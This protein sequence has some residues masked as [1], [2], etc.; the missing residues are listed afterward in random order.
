MR[1]ITTKL[2][3][4]AA[5]LL[6]LALCG[7]RSVPPGVSGQSSP[8]Q[9]AL[10]EWRALTSTSAPPPRVFVRGD[11]I[12]FYFQ[13]KGGV[14][15]FRAGWKRVR[16][17]TPD[18][19]V[20]SAVLSWNQRVTRAP[21]RITQ[22]RQARVISGP[23]WRR[24][25]TNLVAGLAPAKPGRAAYYQA[26]LADGLLYRDQTGA[27]HYAG[28]GDEPPGVQ[29]EARYSIEE[30]LLEL[31]RRMDEALARNH[32]GES[33]FLLMAPNASRVTHPLLLDREQGQCVWLTPAAVLD[34][35]DRSL[36][37]AATLQG[38]EALLLEGHGW[39]LLKNPVS[40]LARLGDLAVQT[41]VRFLHLRLPRL[42]G[43][44]P[45]L[46]LSPGM[47]LAEWE[48]WLD[49]YTG[50]RQQ[51][52]SMEL[53]I[54]GPEFY[55]RFRQ[56]LNE[57]TNRIDMLV[58]IF[59]RD[60]VA[61]DMADL[62][63]QRS[64]QVP[65]RIIFDRLGTIGGGM[66]PPATPLAEGF[67]APNSIYSY[68]ELDSRVQ[69]R[70]YLN[71]WF[72]SEHSK[73][74]LVDKSFAWLGGMNIGREY[75]YEWHDM[76]V[77]VHGP[78]VG[79]LEEEF[80]REWAH[81]GPLGDAAYLGTFLSQRE[82]PDLL[83]GTNHWGQVRLLPTRTLWKPF[84]NAVQAALRKAK[85]YIWVENPYLFD[86]RTILALVRARQR[87]VDVRVILPRANDF[88]AGGRGNLVIA[89]YLLAHGVRV[90]F[91]PGMTHVKA[92]LVDDWACVGSGNLNHLSLRLN[93]EQNIA[94]SDRGFAAQLKDR[95]F[96][97]DFE[98]S[99]ELTHPVSVDWVDFIADLLL[100]GF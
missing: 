44:P 60:D 93:R 16:L 6:C 39:A 33:L 62:L 4:G 23:E 42:K 77:E 78:V 63:K 43:E 9:L 32:P 37:G 86:K 10:D 59:D 20:N 14:E 38:V 64:E 100:E 41:G 80:R 29:I 7:C 75:L 76:M 27:P 8:A 58:Y 74:L 92:F 48:K 26:Y 2:R 49:Q 70:P 53:L 1:A 97:R 85:S 68:L 54:D 56:A 17:P 15:V 65:V 11:E 66:S 46:D 71:P 35:R 89:N 3:S 91:Y 28:L 50:T 45:P 55:A 96:A 21:Q 98:R 36:G 19:E 51:E 99:Y 47:D 81:C 94:T 52:G 24:L 34:L 73:V 22:W 31:A 88:K 30:T 18:Y 90:F 40:S 57:A 61:V 25:S 87:G 67:V 82:Q 5:A 84:G 79:T 13:A 95:L 12:R 83:R 69:V 72:S